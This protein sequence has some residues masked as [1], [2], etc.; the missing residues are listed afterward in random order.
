MT[1]PTETIV[2]ISIRALDVIEAEL[3]LVELSAILVDAVAHGASVN[4]MAGF[5][6]EEGRA[7]WRGQVQG[8]STGDKKILLAESD[9]ELV[10]TVV[11][12]FAHQPNACH[13]AEVGKMLVLSSVRR[14][15]I[16]RRLLGA[17]ETAALEAGRTLLLPD[18]ETGSGGDLLY[19]SCGWIEVG[20]VPDQA[21][22]PDGCLAATTMFYK[23][24]G[25][26]RCH[27]I[28]TQ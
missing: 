2:E 13:R 28:A 15:G 5:S 24:L 1:N 23:T 27:P 20:T 3:R 18:T 7:F 8:L 21:F 12:T 25:L 17:A 19:R 10:G 26:H 11:L 16:G 9:Q 6:D 14:R 22:R 4:F